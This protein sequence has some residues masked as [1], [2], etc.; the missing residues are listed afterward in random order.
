[1]E[2][3][4]VIEFGNGNTDVWDDRADALKYY[5]TAPDDILDA[6]KSGRYMGLLE[7]AL[8]APKEIA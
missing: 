4:Y 6:V 2:K 7:A 1:M 3:V 8:Y 5:A